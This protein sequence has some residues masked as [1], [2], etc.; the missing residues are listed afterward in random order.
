M[1]EETAKDGR[2]QRVCGNCGTTMLGDHCY[3]CGQPVK[4][5]VRQFSSIIGDFLDSVFD[6]DSRTLRTLGPLFYRP[7]HLSQ[8]YFTGRRVRYVS[9]VRLF[10][11]LCIIAFFVLSQ[12]LSP[13]LD[14]AVT[15]NSDAFQDTATVA[16]VE[17]KRD[18]ILQDLEKSKVDLSDAPGA[19]ASVNAAMA[20]LQ[21]DA[22][23]R[24]AEL[25]PSSAPAEPE[26]R[27][28]EPIRLSFGAEEWDL[29][30]NPVVID[31]LPDAGNAW[32][33]GV[34]GQAKGN[35]AR[36]REE[37]RLLLETFLRTLPQTFFVLLPVFALL[38]KLTYLFKRRLY[39]E[40]L[41]VALHS[42]AFLC[43]SLL[44][45][46]LIDTI[47]GWV[48]AGIVGSALTGAER[49]VFLW[50]PIYLLIAQKRIYQQ[51]WIMTIIKFSLLGL[52]Y[53]LLLSVAAVVNLG[54]S[55]VWL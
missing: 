52:A 25:E 55:L 23:R 6:F 2:P 7:G 29:E 39:M 38:L 36:V 22:N 12:W 20:A 26:V 21:A 47:R 4:G 28:S 16:E 24:I 31:W 54:F 48:G 19:S 10:V 27:E 5:L 18:R 11:F 33:N 13:D 17:A 40:H 49:A 41:I 50:M 46:V 15:L 14:S 3:Q 32:L 43:L 37:P 44:L 30:S 53:S 34:I 51:G 45:I 35:A 8:E 1:S 42:H 9:P